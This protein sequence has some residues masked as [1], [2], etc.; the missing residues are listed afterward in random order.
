MA[1]SIFLK[2]AIY[3]MTMNNLFSEHLII[4]IDGQTFPF[5]LTVLWCKYEINASIHLVNHVSFGILGRT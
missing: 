4:K 2:N 3:S 5:S 1:F